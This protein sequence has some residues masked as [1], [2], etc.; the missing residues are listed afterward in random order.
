MMGFMALIIVAAGASFACVYLLTY[1]P[2]IKKIP[3][4]FLIFIY[5]M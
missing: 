1:V 5:W 4:I 2:I 3:Y